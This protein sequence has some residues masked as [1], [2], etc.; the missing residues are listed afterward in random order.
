MAT[1][2]CPAVASKES[3]VGLDAR[4]TSLNATDPTFPHDHVLP[5][6]TRNHI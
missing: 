2:Y 4:S 1:W 5:S 3:L 6:D